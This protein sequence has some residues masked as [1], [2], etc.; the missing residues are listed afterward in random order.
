MKTKQKETT[1]PISRVETMMEWS[2]IS[3]LKVNRSIEISEE[4]P[5][6]IRNDGRKWKLRRQRALWPILRQNKF[7]ARHRI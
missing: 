6:G 3:S 1:Q 2:C 7:T 5:I 4:M